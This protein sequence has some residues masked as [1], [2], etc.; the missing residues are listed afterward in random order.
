MNAVVFPSRLNG[1]VKIPGSKSV[2]QRLCAL[3][4]L[5]AGTTIIHH[6]DNSDDSETA[7]KIISVLGA[8][9]T[10]EEDFLRVESSGEVLYSGELNF[11]ESGLAC[12]MFL[13]IAALSR[14]KISLTGEGSLLKR[15]LTFFNEVLP[16]LGVLMLSK[17][18]FLPFV[19]RGPLVPQRIQVDGSESSQGITGLLYAFASSV[20][21]NTLLS[22][23]KVVS[24][25][26][27]D[28]SISLLEPFGMSA[29]WMTDDRIF[30]FPRKQI[31]G[32]VEVTVEGDWS[33]AAFLL[34]A[35][36]LCGDIQIE[37]LNPHS[38]QG[39]KF[40]LDIFSK[41][42]IHYS[43]NKLGVSVKQQRDFK[44]FTCDLT[45]TPDLFP[46]LVVLASFANGRSVLKGA[47]RLVNKES[48]R[49]VELVKMF[50]SLGVN[51]FFADDE[52]SVEGIG[53]VNG[54]SVD[55]VNDHRM[56]MAAAI[57]ALAADG[58]ITIAGAGAVSKSYPEFFTGLQQL[59]AQVSL[60]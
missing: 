36:V 24:K 19:I 47:G 30:I 2:M 6:P 18:G 33:S 41:I 5:H 1:K 9:I 54:G 49:A 29:K 14:N 58:P 20:K 17:D 26:Y 60:I 25:P 27:I 57:A 46:P 44:S 35:G 59:G 39:D 50:S 40:I 42:G 51:L 43:I 22:V 10:Q 23:T 13:P 3:A 56:V 21:A 52:I 12:R 45:H 7:L 8:S 55:G 11:G 37:N 4:L 34:I 38:Q 32:N 16:V 15:P 53:K 31:L 48:N 28:L